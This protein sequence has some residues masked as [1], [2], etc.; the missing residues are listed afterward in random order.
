MA[1][2]ALI[3]KIPE[4]EYNILKNSKMPMT[5]AEHL[6]SKGIPVPEG[7]SFIAMCNSDFPI[8]EETKEKLKDTV[9]VGDEYCNYC[10][11]MTEIIEVR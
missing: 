1:E 6:I 4:K 8:T 5:W 2:I 7:H 3:I 11:D 10:F 9:F